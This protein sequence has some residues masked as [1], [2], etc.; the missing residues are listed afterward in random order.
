MSGQRA[1][2]RPFLKDRIELFCKESRAGS[3]AVQ[4]SYRK[5]GEI[6]AEVHPVKRINDRYI[7]LIQGLGQ[8]IADSMYRIVVRTQSVQQAHN[9]FLQLL[10]SQ[11]NQQ[12]WHAP[13]EESEQIGEMGPLSPK[14]LRA[15]DTQHRRGAVLDVLLKPSSCSTS[16]QTFGD[17][18]CA[19]KPFLKINTIYWKRKELGLVFPFVIL[20]NCGIFSESFGIEK[21][22]G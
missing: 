19:V 3:N 12:D 14:E 21:G 8:N 20:D 15:G 13:S 6:W 16:S 7:A 1:L 4:T 5:I 11:Q 2:K 18:G 9:K 22:E 10:N 17:S